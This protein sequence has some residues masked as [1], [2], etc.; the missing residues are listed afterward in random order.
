MER[1]LSLVLTCIAPEELFGDVE[2]VPEQLWPIIADMNGLPC[3]GGGLVTPYCLERQCVFL[4][5]EEEVR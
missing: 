2:N 1:R 4:D 3:E 5:V